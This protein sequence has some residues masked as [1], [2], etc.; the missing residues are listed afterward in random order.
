[1][2]SRLRSGQALS[3]LK[4]EYLEH[5]EVEK[6]RSLLTVRNYDH[7]LRRFLDWAK[8]DKPS[9]ITSDLIREYRLHLNRLENQLGKALK[10]Q[11]QNYHLIALRNFLKYMAK[12]DINTL[13]A[14]KIELAKMPSRDMEFMESEELARLLKAPEGNNLK[15]LRDRAI[16][17]LFFST[18]LRLSE[19]TNLNRDSVNLK[20]GE[21]SVRGKGDKIRIVFLS[22][23][24][25]DAL[26][27]YLDARKDTD[28]AMFARDVKDPSKHD[29]LRLTPRSVERMVKFYAAKAGITKKVTPHQ[30]RH[31]FATDLLR[32]GADIRSVQ[33]LLGHSHITTTQI[34]THVTDKGLREIHQKFHSPSR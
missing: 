8:I 33:A 11:T 23:T 29:E 12:R 21:F 27:K 24:A 20:K 10:K 6:N 25:R 5:L 18:G 2:T 34:Y 13:A 15:T 26:K 28:E 14:E 30:L 17:E 32:N 16:L 3:E 9:E 4:K 22:D 31:S 7:Y 1:M 19:L